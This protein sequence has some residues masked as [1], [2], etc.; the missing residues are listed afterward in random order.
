MTAMFGI[1][2]VN[3]PHVDV[4]RWAKKHKV[5]LPINFRQTPEQEAMYLKILSMRHYFVKL[6]PLEHQARVAE[7]VQEAMKYY[8][9]SGLTDRAIVVV[10]VAGVIFF[11]ILFLRDLA[12][13]KL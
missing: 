12:S 10:Q 3:L 9:V 4:Y 2:S 8:P 1:N 7:A 5:F 11:A 6:P 13:S